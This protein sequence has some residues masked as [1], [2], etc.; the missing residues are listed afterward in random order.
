MNNSFLKT[1][2]YDRHNKL[3]AKLV[4]FAGYLMPISY[5]TGIKNEYNAVRKKVGMFDVSH[6]GQIYV[7]GKEA[8]TFLNYLSIN[9]V[10]NML[11]GS[12]QYNIFCND[13]GGV[14]DDVII[15]RKSKNNYL[16][17]VNASN[18]QK[19]YDWLSK[20]NQ[21]NLKIN[22]VSEK[23]SILAIQGPK[24]RKVLY[25]HFNMNLEKLK[26]YTFTYKKIFDEEILISRTGYTGELGY[27]IIAN[28]QII[29]KI[30]D[31]LLV[32]DVIPCGLAVR[33]VLRIE[34]KYC[35][36]GNDLLDTINPIQAGLKW[37]VDLS[38]KNFVGREIIQEEINNPTK[39]L[40]CFKMIDKGIAR[41]NYRVFI[42]G[43]SVGYVSSGT[44]SISLNCGI[45]LAFID[46]KYLNE[47]SIFI[48]IRNRL[49]EAKTVK[50]PFIN[51]FSLHS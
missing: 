51:N 15:Y 14:I 42:S 34:M 39:R 21:Y 35:L 24:S 17:I 4:P 46:K 30:W 16:I 48:E 40:I 28:H 44:F 19:N 41:K 50:P 47:N 45:G 27:E 20:N 9:N 38:K 31:V 32:K 23:F 5:K 8:D 18:I 2:L 6:M 10:K 33:D 25:E 7:E 29:Q 3:E 26:F 1:A 37:V 22:N 43:K 11:D 49:F 12:A 36:Y 13:Q